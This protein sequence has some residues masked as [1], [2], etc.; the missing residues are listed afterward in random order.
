[1]PPLTPDNSP[2]KM[3]KGQFAIGCSVSLVLLALLVGAGWLVFSKCTAGTDTSPPITGK[4]LEYQLGLGIHLR[5]FQTFFEEPHNGSFKFESSELDDGTPV[6]KGMSP[7][8]YGMMILMGPPDDLSEVSFAIPDRMDGFLDNLLRMQEFL[9][10]ATPGWSA[11]KAWLL[12]S[13]P[14]INATNPAVHTL[15]KRRAIEL[16]YFRPKDADVDFYVIRVV[17]IPE[18]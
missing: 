1:M 17:S 12:E 10:M 11:R 8:S 15:Q 5:T 16:R 9:E 7:E 18:S 14:I 3:S 13:M 4:Q 6:T 2:E